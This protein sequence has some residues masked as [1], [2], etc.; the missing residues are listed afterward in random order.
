MIGL[1]NQCT[2]LRSGLGLGLG[3]GLRLPEDKPVYNPVMPSVAITCQN[4]VM[5]RVRVYCH[6][7]IMFLSEIL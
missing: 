7:E 4:R 3:L 1:L 6:L 5:V 2:S